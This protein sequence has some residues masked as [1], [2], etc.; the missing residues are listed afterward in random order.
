[1]RELF[2]IAIVSIALAAD[3]VSVTLAIGMRSHEHTQK[4]AFR[5]SVPFGF[6]QGAMTLVGWAIG[7]ALAS[8]IAG[9]G[10]IVG[11][12]LLSLIGLKMIKDGL[13]KSEEVVP[14]HPN[15]RKIF[16]LSIATSIDALVVGTTIA[17]LELPLIFA[18]AVIALTTFFLCYLTYF[19]SKHAGKLF[20]EYVEVVA[21]IVLIFVGISFLIF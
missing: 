20:G 4:Q 17:I 15:A 2:Q 21:G 10:S 14:E 3:A 7:A 19:L 18:S 11:L 9:A 16:L 12:A 8:L 6:F 1:M 13:S 5:L